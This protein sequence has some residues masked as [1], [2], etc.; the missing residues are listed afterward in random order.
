MRKSEVEIRDVECSEWMQLLIF[1]GRR[2]NSKFC[3]FYQPPY[4][5]VRRVLYCSSIRRSQSCS[6]CILQDF[7]LQTLFYNEI[8]F[9][10]SNHEDTPFSLFS[11]APND[12]FP[13]TVLSS[14]RGSFKHH[15]ATFGGRLLVIKIYLYYIC[16]QISSRSRKG[17]FDEQSLTWSSIKKIEKRVI[18]G[19]R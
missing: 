1:E 11:T 12:F 10:F 2:W 3:T 15:S 17:Q 8:S 4:L 14:C 13:D 6:V 9:Q 19:R 16:H 18:V 7:T 5:V